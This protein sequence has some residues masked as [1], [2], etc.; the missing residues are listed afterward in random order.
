MSPQTLRGQICIAGWGDWPGWGRFILVFRRF[1][2]PS[3]APKSY[4]ASPVLN[5][6]RVPDLSPKYPRELGGCSGTDSGPAGSDRPSLADSEPRRPARDGTATPSRYRPDTHYRGRSTGSPIWA[7]GGT[8]RATA[9]D[10]AKGEIIEGAVYICVRS[11]F[12]RV[13]KC[14]HFRERSP[15]ISDPRNFDSP[16]V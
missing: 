13:G 1:R 16:L 15:P 2:V 14:S 6:G 3:C 10:T 8:R 5:R 9:D 4:G 11:C 12:C 7:V